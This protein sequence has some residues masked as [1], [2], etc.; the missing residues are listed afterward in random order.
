[1]RASA[2]CRVGWGGWAVTSLR[3]KMRCDASQQQVLPLG[4]AEGPRF[5]WIVL[6]NLHGRKTR[7]WTRRCM[8][9][10]ERKTCL[11]LIGWWWGEERGGMFWSNVP[12]GEDW[13]VGLPVSASE[14]LMRVISRPWNQGRQHPG[15]QGAGTSQKCVS[16]CECECV[17]VCACP[18]R[19]TRL[20]VYRCPQKT[21]A[22]GMPP[23][24][25]SDRR[26]TPSRKGGFTLSV[27]AICT[28]LPHSSPIS[29]RKGNPFTLPQACTNQIHTVMQTHRHRGLLCT[30]GRSLC[31]LPI[32]IYAPRLVFKHI[33]L[34]WT[35][36]INNAHRTY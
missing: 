3:S 27:G 18:R 21:N 10:V 31:F 26:Q 13:F 25:T 20:P 4:P 17:S 23:A 22:G 2:I 24:N 11:V 29:G 19:N 15:R 14:M 32:R 35:I 33:P 9:E 7:G 36:P 30:E 8:S 5:P 12:Q 34:K 16:V 6:I 1:M 28:E